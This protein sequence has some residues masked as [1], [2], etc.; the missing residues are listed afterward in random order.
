MGCH[1]CV[2]VCR[3]CN[4]EIKIDEFRALIYRD[5]TFNLLTHHG[6]CFAKYKETHLIGEKAKARGRI[7]GLCCDCEKPVREN[8][9][10]R[11]WRVN[12]Q[13]DEDESVLEELMLTTIPQNDFIMFTHNGCN[14]LQLHEAGQLNTGE[15]VVG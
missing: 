5:E 9:G 4:K 2:P 11:V 10:F 14:N 15:T 1:Y 13:Q 6:A 7:L 12:R 8:D 3:Q